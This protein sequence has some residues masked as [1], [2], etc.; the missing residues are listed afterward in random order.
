MK[1][2]TIF[3]RML[4]DDPI[5]L[6][7]LS[8]IEELENKVFEKKSKKYIS[9]EESNAAPTKRVF[10]HFLD[11]YVKKYGNPYKVVGNK[12]GVYIRIANFMKSH[13]LSVSGYCSFLDFAFAHI[14]TSTFKPGIGHLCSPVILEMVENS[15]V[16]KNVPDFRKLRDE[17]RGKN[18]S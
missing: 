1:F 6:D 10:N 16:K 14:F 13:E 12:A 8:Y 18:L 7:L 5:E 15:R 17:L 3:V 11:L 4:L 2:P 9:K